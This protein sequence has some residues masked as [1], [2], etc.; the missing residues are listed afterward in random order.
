MADGFVDALMKLRPNNAPSGQHKG[1]LSPKGKKG[2]KGSKVAP[3]HGKT[4]KPMHGH[5]G[6]K[7]TY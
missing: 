4:K 1:R 5:H 7:P 6:G 3:M 2:P